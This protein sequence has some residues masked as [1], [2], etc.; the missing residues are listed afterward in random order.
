MCDFSAKNVKSLTYLVFVVK[1]VRVSAVEA[2]YPA[3]TFSPFELRLHNISRP[4]QRL[5]TGKLRVVLIQISIKPKAQIPAGSDAS[6]WRPRNA[7]SM[8]SFCL[9]ELYPATWEKITSYLKTRP[10]VYKKAVV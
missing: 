10:A 8:G 2:T 9:F 7:S 1:S 3:R 4:Q 5:P 6:A